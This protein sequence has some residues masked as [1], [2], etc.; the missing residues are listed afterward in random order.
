MSGDYWQPI[1][2]TAKQNPEQAMR[3]L[4][5][6][7]QNLLDAIKVRRVQRVPYHFHMKDAGN[8][9]GY[10]PMY[11]PGLNIERD[12]MGDVVYTGDTAYLVARG[13]Y[14]IDVTIL[15]DQLITASG[16]FVYLRLNGETILSPEMTISST[17]KT[18]IG[19]TNFYYNAY[20]YDYGDRTAAF[21]I[22]P[23]TLLEVY[24][25]AASS[26]VVPTTT[27]LLVTVNI[28]HTGED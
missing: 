14:V 2:P 18:R 1:L 23:M 27:N 10:Q 22:E 11:I 6:Q 9:L 21:R 13:G 25:R 7:M 17:L 20:K 24:F 8:A 4:D 12:E 16:W 26:G 28:A 5:Y 19:S 3:I 15:A